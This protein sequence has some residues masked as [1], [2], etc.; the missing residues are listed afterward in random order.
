M[1]IENTIRMHLKT[2][3]ED[4]DSLKPFMK[5]WLIKVETEIQRRYDQQTAAV[6]MIKASDYSVKSIAAEIGAA[7]TTMYNHEQLLKRYIETSSVCMVINNPY[8]SISKLQT[9]KQIMQAQINKMMERDVD[10]ELLK[11]QNRDLSVAL[12][13]KNAEIARLQER[14]S[15]LS[16]ENA[17]LKASGTSMHKTSI[18]AFKKG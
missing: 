12:E 15:A 5:N 16:A 14:L 18:K 1:D 2:M 3:G 9:E 6:E 8:A 13:G 10:I 17:S 4:Y 11:S 7:R